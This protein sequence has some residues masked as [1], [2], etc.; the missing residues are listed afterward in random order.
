MSLNI[1]LIK[2]PILHKGASF[3]LMPTPPLGL[4]YIAGALK[5]KGYQLQVVDASAEG[6]DDFE[7]FRDEIYIFGLNKD[8]IVSRIHQNVDIICFSFMFTNN[9]LYGREVVKA[10]RERFP[11]AILIA[12]GEHATAAPEY[13]MH[14]APLDYIVLGEGEETIVELVEVLKNNGNI[15]AVGGIAYRK[16]EEIVCNRRRK[17]IKA[18][19][20]I[21]WPAWEIFPLKEYFEHKMTH[22]VYRGNSLPVM[23]TRGCPYTCT[24]CSNPQMWG[25]AYEMRP[26][27]DFVDELEYLHKT[28]E[29]VNFD[30]YDLT[31]IMFKDWI[32]AMCQEI[33]KRDLKISYQ[34]PSGTRAEAIDF[35]VADLLFKSGCINMTYAPESGS[36]RVLHSVKKQVDIQ[37]MLQSIADSNKAGMIV[38]L[39]MI[40]GFPDDTHK[41]MWQTIW[42][43]AKCSWYGAH[44]IAPAVFTPYP[45]STL[46]N[47]LTKQGKLNIYND[48]CI[49]EIINSYDLWPNKVY[50][51]K[52]SELSVKMYVFLFTF[53]FYGTNYLFRPIRLF[54]TIR[55]ILT[56]KHESRLEQILYKNFIKN[57]LNIKSLN[58]VFHL[59]NKFSHFLNNLL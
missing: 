54:K 49:V 31:A 45:G 20:D 47:R 56:N 10:V 44:D 30:L 57:F 1:C 23:A 58:K 16:Q 42:F 51:E 50:S 53:V 2:P 38:H 5:K 52:I 15:E 12:G 21:P 40:L 7:Y 26:P 13:C 14:Q 39:N 34:L 24:F 41:D 11:K 19:Q 4:A 9:W 18:I 48:D 35:E 25:K 59:K 17:R 22:G 3:A 33:L 32:V 29:V 55:N 36:K 6:V 8:K 37:Q 43:L 27:E 28:Y 46:Y